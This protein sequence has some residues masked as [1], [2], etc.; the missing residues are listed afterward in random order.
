MNNRPNKGKGNEGREIFARKRKS[1]RVL[2]NISG[3]IYET[4]FKTLERFPQTLLGSHEKRLLYY[5]SS[6]RQF[7]F[8]RCKLFF[9]SILFFYQSN[10]ILQCPDKIPID[11]FEEECR[12]FQIPEDA[13]KNLRSK[14]RIFDAIVS[15]DE[16]VKV[17]NDTLKLKIWNVLQ[18]PETSKAAKYFAIFSIFMITLSVASSCLETLPSL[19]VETSILKDNPWAITELALNSWFLLEF[20][21]VAICTPNRKHFFRCSMTWLDVVVII[22][23]FV[24]LTISTDAVSSLRFL[25][26]IRLVRVGRLFRLSKH[27]KML[28]IVYK[29]LRSSLQDF[30]AMLICMA[31]IVFMGGSLMYHLESH[32]SDSNFTDILV[33]IYWGIQT[34]T[35]LGYG[36]IHPQTIPGMIFASC[37]M[38][39]GAMTVSMPVLSIITKFASAY[40]GKFS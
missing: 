38:T 10:G 7:F 30:K 1:G 17:E 20:V 19:K 4:N 21:A 3:E 40:E 26:I 6:S 15:D 12:F 34:I 37:F 27:S 31:V 32:K 18:N 36:D 24:V 22:P 28:K 14:G 8:Q 39:F 25:R 9:D 2:L 35:T 16:S 13:I 29:V 33:S 5:C 11:L 23:Y